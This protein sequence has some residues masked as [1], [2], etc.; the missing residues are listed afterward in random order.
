MPSTRDR[1]EV[2]LNGHPGRPPGAVLASGGCEHPH[3][4][5]RGT[6]ADQHPRGGALDRALAPAPATPGARRR[7]AARR[8]GRPATRPSLQAIGRQPGDRP[9]RSG[10]ARSSSARCRCRQA[11]TIARA[12][13]QRDVR[14][15]DRRGGDLRR[16]RR[17][18]R[19]PT[20]GRS[21]RRTPTSS[22]ATPTTW[23]R[24]LADE[25]TESRD[26]PRSGPQLEATRE[27]RRPA[28]ADQQAGA[29]GRAR[30]GDRGAAPRRD[31]RT[32][33]RGGPDLERPRG[34]VA[35]PRSARS[36]RLPAA[37]RQP[38]RPR[39]HGRAE[40][41]TSSSARSSWSASTRPGDF[42]NYVRQEM[43]EG[44][45]T[46]GTGKFE[47]MLEPEQLRGRGRRSTS[48]P[49]RA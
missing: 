6:A 4:R 27:A 13:R 49:T 15:R 23:T 30:P 42:E 46:A 38:P 16:A 21:A 1:P 37:D 39:L 20:T 32:G 11:E 8:S 26:R 45:V 9:G 28:R 47:W 17:V 40:R 18:A 12:A 31:A 25:L 44:I 7:V 10:R 14:P 48:S 22:S 5:S 29:T 3:R 35:R 41:A 36:R 34:P 24:D 33:H 2:C 43:T 19:R